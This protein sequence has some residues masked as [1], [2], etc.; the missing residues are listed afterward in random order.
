MRA[1]LLLVIS[2]CLVTI[3]LPA[4]ADLSSHHQQKCCCAHDAASSHHD[5]DKIDNGCDEPVKTQDRQCCVGCPLGLALTA[6]NIKILVFPKRQGKKFGSGDIFGPLRADR[7]P[8]P[9]PGA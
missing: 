1:L 6:K 3:S 9:P 5:G 2:L 4:Q 7:P 8:V